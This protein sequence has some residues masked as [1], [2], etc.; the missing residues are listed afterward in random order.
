MLLVPLTLLPY[1]SNPQG[2]FMRFIIL[3]TLLTLSAHAQKLVPYQINWTSAFTC[4][5]AGCPVQF[6]RW[7]RRVLHSHPALR[8]QSTL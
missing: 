5:S 1:L 7:A 3:V 6:S 2:K 8:C 4:A